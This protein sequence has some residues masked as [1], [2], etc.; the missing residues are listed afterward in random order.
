MRIA[1]VRERHAPAGAPWRLAAAD[2]SEAAGTGRP[3][4]LDRPRARPVGGPSPTVPRSRT[5]APST[6][7]R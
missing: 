2:P 3:D 5:T 1:H 4:P 7:S 6:A